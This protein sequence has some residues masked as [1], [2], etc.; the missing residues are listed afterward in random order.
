MQPV[1]SVNRVK[2]VER[3]WA[4]HLSGSTWPLMTRA[5][6]AVA[7]LACHHWPG[8]KYAWV[9]AGR[10]NNGGD[11]YIAATRLRA[12]GVTVTVI[13]PSG[14]PKPDT[15]AY[16]AWQEYADQ[17][18]TLE[19]SLPYDSPDLV[20]DALIGTGHVGE[21]K[22]NLVDLLSRVRER[23]APV[24]AVDAPS[25]LNAATGQADLALLK[26]DRTI[27]FIAY[28]PG[29]LTG[30]GPAVCGELVLETLGIDLPTG[31]FWGDGE[32]AYLDQ[33][34]DRPARPGD[35][36]KGQFGGVR[37]IA[38]AEGM[39]GAGLLAARAALA[40]GA[41]KVYWHTSPEQAHSALIAQPELMS[42][43]LTAD[44]EPDG[45]IHVL[46]PGLGQDDTAGALYR[47]L[48]LDDHDAR[49]VL[50]ADGLTWLA[51]YPKP[52]HNWV[53]TPHPGEAACLLG[54][55]TKDI[56]NDRCQ[57]VMELS[58]RFQ[59]TVILKGAGSLIAHQGRLYFNHPGDPAMATPGMGDTLAGLI[60]GLMAQGLGQE[61]AAKTGAWW[62]AKLGAQLAQRYRI[63]L[64]TDLIEAIRL[65]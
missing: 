65:R 1:L 30:Q 34:L 8:L 24:L 18:G 17:G 58:D 40:A 46:G 55:S 9:L 22:A 33:A 64:A 56:Q 61:E 59:T 28:K 44:Y 45:S 6:S 35:S 5:G 43:E 63:V 19:S 29:L 57:A 52:V 31:G 14:E 48:L 47:R 27:S 15:D 38:G 39:G 23:R 51:R 42:T 3:E 7:E 2:A 4:E 50:D 13:A 54:Q 25:G 60:A 36:H 20:I 11:G 37:V 26:A 10:G 21:L 53:L 12:V 32:A 41:G 49:G 62:H 16:R